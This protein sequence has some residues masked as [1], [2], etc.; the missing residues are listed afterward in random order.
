MHAIPINLAGPDSRREHVPV[1]I[2]AICD[3]IER[4]YTSWAPI[5]IAIEEQQFDGGC[6]TR[7]D[8]EIDTVGKDSRPEGMTAASSVKAARRGQLLDCSPIENCAHLLVARPLSLAGFD[9]LVERFVVELCFQEISR[10]RQFD[11]K[12]MQRT[13][14]KSSVAKPIIQ[15]VPAALFILS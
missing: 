12:I 10:I 4:D 8:A 13:N 2:S 1:I 3:W 7:E 5:I 14:L 9:L 6:A 15:S 11:M